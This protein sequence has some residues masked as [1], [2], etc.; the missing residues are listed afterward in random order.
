MIEVK[1]QDWEAILFLTQELEN[2]EKDKAIKAGLGA[3]ARV[4]L[5][6]GKQTLRERMKYRTGITG[7]LLSS[8]T[9]R[10]K[11]SKPGALS[12]FKWPQGNHAHLVDLGT[13]ER[14]RKG[15]KSTGAM[16]ANYFWTDT[17]DSAGPNAIDKLYRGVESA[18]DRINEGRR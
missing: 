2:F 6:A 12:G 17:R 7:N 13:V 11:K 18:V 15:N 3:A 4:F 14:F 10:V 9:V 16:P 1:F 5:Q 8:F